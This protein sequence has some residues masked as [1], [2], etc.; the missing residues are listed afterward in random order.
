MRPSYTKQNTAAT[1]MNTSVNSLLD[2]N[3]PRS[4]H[5]PPGKLDKITML[6]SELT[7]IDSE[8]NRPVDASDSFAVQTQ[9][10]RLQN[11]FADLRQMR[12]E[13]GAITGGKRSAIIDRK[14]R[15]CLD[16]ADRKLEV[17][18]RR[19][20]ELGTMLDVQKQWDQLYELLG[21]WLG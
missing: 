17:L 2:F 21:K 12:A 5:H 3:L 18:R 1:N 20:D 9:R 6:Q 11:R 10:I 4:Y 19:I 13:A 16:E 8:I 14:A 7:D 15:L